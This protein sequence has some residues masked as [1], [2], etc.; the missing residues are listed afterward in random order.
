MRILQLAPRTPFPEDDGGK[1]GIANITKE[2]A[3]LGADITLLFFYNNEKDL[4]IPDYAYQY[5]N[6]VP[7]YHDTSNSLPKILRSALLFRSIYIDKHNSRKVKNFINHHLIENKY[8]VIH[9]DHTAMAD[10]GLYCQKILKCPIGLRLHNIEWTIWQ[11]Y[12]QS[13]SPADPRYYY[14]QQQAK[15]LRKYE[16]DAI[17]KMDIN[18]AITKEDLSRALEMNSTANVTISTAGVNIDEWK[19]DSAVSRNPNELIHATVYRWRHNLKAITWF[20]EEVMPLIK[21]KNPDIYLRLLGK[22][23]PDSLREYGKQ[24]EVIGYVDSVLPY[25]NK[26]GIY[27]AP[28]FV[29]GGIR[30]KILEAMAMEM[31]IVA[32]PIAAEGIRATNKDGLFIAHNKNDFADIIIRLNRDDKLRESAGIAARKFIEE[33]H[34]WAKNVKIIY[35]EYERLISEKKYLQ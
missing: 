32:S 13:L 5:A 7:V 9:C 18:F 10:I 31:P 33:N 27:V 19:A 30:I 25:L 6:I 2:L 35:D 29:G 22:N 17:G 12:Y 34:T 8:D 16:S 20:I 21:A 28:L 14:L 24:V 23:A 4:D 15:L 1:I 11:R 26:A 3:K